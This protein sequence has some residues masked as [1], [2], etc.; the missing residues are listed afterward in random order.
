[1]NSYIEES[2]VELKSDSNDVHMSSTDKNEAKMHGDPK[3]S[4]VNEKVFCVWR[5]VYCVLRVGNF[6][7][8]ISEEASDSFYMHG[9]A[10]PSGMCNSARTLAPS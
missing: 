9:E 7:S 10:S 6:G 1:M 5:V 4:P 8:R 3:E 2:D